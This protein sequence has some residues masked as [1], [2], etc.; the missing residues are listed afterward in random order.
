M[1]TK[2]KILL[3][4]AGVLLIGILVGIRFLA[5]LPY[6]KGDYRKVESPNGR[7]LAYVYMVTDMGFFSGPRDVYTFKVDWGAP[8]GRRIMVYEREIGQDKVRPRVD[9]TQEDVLAS[10]SEDS[11]IVTFLPE[12]LDLEVPVPF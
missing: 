7:H 6:P 2:R 8:D 5:L 12:R 11:H 9:L 1:T 10:W 3:A 4:G